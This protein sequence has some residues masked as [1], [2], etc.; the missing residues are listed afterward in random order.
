MQRVY[1]PPPDGVSRA[2]SSNLDMADNSGCGSSGQEEVY[3]EKDEIDAD[4]RVGRTAL[5]LGIFLLRPCYSGNSNCQVSSTA[6]STRS[7]CSGARGRH[8]CQCA[9]I[10]Q[11]GGLNSGLGVA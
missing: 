2:A 6:F 8:F 7:F 1:V 9:R 4:S 10:C 3:N 11:T 5:S